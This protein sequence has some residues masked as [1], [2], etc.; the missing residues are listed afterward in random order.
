VVVVVVASHV[1]W[2]AVENLLVL[3]YGKVLLGESLLDT[4]V[5]EHGA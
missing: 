3:H 4:S 5:G 2:G 1:S